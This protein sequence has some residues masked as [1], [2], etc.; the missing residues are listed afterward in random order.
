VIIFDA[1]FVRVTKVADQTDPGHGG[2]GYEVVVGCFRTKLALI[3]MTPGY[4]TVR[5]G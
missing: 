5:V 4:R 2:F 3:C 1:R